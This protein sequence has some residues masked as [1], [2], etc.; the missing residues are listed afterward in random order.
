MSGPQVRIVHLSAEALGALA[1]G[2]LEA[3]SAASPV[4]LTPWLVSDEAIGTWR[5]RVRQVADT[6]ADLGWVTGVIWDDER[7]VVVGKAGFH[8][9]PDASGMVE[10]G[11]AVDPAERRRGYARA[12]LLAMLDRARAEPSV[13]T[14]RATVSPTNT[15]SLGL[16]AQL[17]FAEVGEQWDDEDGLETIYELP[18]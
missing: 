11:Y 17:P 2:D 14:F 1:A 13:R 10:V 12:A 16:I 4:P 3:A 6:P 8:G 18:V 9:A 5:Y 7:E 15:A